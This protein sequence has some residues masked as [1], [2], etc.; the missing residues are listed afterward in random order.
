MVEAFSVHVVCPGVC[1]LMLVRK[2][3]VCKV[4]SVKEDN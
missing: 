2:E 3:T 1:V 4:F